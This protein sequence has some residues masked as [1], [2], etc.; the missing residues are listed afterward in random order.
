MRP[1]WPSRRR[2]RASVP[3]LPSRPSSRWKASS[4]SSP[5][6]PPNK[7]HVVSEIKSPAVHS[8]AFSYWL[9]LSRHAQWLTAFGED[10]DAPALVVICILSSTGPARISPGG[11]RT[12]VEVDARQARHPHQARRHRSGSSDLKGRTAA[13][14]GHIGRRDRNRLR[15]AAIVKGGEI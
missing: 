10:A 12:E 9:G 13:A 2:S 1:S 3:I 4:P 5:R 8:R 6:P 15:V 7:P 14:T 11:G